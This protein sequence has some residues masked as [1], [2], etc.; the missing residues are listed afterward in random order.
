MPH[1]FKAFLAT[2]L[3]CVG[4]TLDT[5]AACP[6]RRVT[7]VVPY[8][9][10]GPTDALAR[11]LADQFS[12]SWGVPVLVENRTGANGIIATASVARAPGDGHTILVQLTGL[13]QNA[14]LYKKL[15][16][17]PFTDLAA[18]ARIGTQPMALAVGRTSPSTDLRSLVRS[19]STTP[20]FGTYGS[21]GAGSTGHIYGELLRKATSSPLT[22]VPHRGEALLLPE[23]I[24][25][26]I[27][28]A[29]VSAATAIDSSRAGTLRVLG[30]TGP[31]RLPA[32]PDVP[33][34]AEAGLAGFELLGWYGLFVPKGTPS[35]MAECIAEHTEAALQHT[36]MVQRLQ[37]LAVERRTAGPAAFTSALR[38]D[39]GRWDDLIKRFGIALEQE[40]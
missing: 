36:D 3:L 39:F 32:L 29:F 27:D 21:F 13:I 17:D 19:F 25:G 24:S 1:R 26:R 35:A 7:M 31:T 2:T 15:P 16:Y 18:V 12:K 40:P 38:E 23:L 4:A 5:S 8:S 28:L 33:T 6:N 30:V 20:K 11:S 34:M 37:Q 22:H 9:A 14:S 10:G